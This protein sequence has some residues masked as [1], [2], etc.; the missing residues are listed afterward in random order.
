MKWKNGDSYDGEWKNGKKNGYGVYVSEDGQIYE[1]YWVDNRKEGQ[2]KEVDPDGNIYEGEWKHD[3]HDGYGIE[4]LSGSKYTGMWKAGVKHGKGV[5]YFGTGNRYD[6]EWIED[7]KHGE[8]I[9]INA[10]GSKK[11]QVWDNGVMISE[12]QIDDDDEPPPSYKESLPSVQI[13]S[14]ADKSEKSDKTVDKNEKTES[15]KL[16]EEKPTDSNQKV[17]KATSEATLELFRYKVINFKDLKLQ[18]PELGEGVYGKVYKAKWLGTEVAV[19][20]MKIKSLPEKV[21]K[22]FKTEIAVLSDLRHPNL[23]LFLGASIEPPNLCIVYEF[24][25]KGNLYD[26]LR[27]HEVTQK[28]RLKMAIDI[29]IG[30]NYM[31]YSQERPIIHRDLKSLNVLVDKTLTMKICDFGLAVVMDDEHTHKSQVGTVRWTAPEILK[32]EKYT[33]KVD[34]YSYGIILWELFTI[35][36]A[37]PYE[38]KTTGEVKSFIL[39][40]QRPPMPKCPKKY[41]KLIEDCWQ[42]NANA[43]PNFKDI[44]ESLEEIKREEYPEE[45]DKENKDDENNE[46]EEDQT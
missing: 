14:D 29:A 20:K 39:D 38:G 6:G 43:R 27:D 22:E 9:K 2:G 15:Y 17:K 45:A 40:G 41:S 35:P 42:E 24:M 21:L 12:S 32:G 4:T 31:H 30:M 18:K 34:V 36:P 13:T 46:D 28:E 3:E 10:D 26:Y 7:R 19:K 8:G 37:V 33:E 25:E 44:L 1:G 5:Y 23:I 16:T 11:K